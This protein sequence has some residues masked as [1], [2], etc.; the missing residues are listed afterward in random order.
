GSS[1]TQDA[2]GHLG[3]DGLA[4]ADGDAA[5]LSILLGASTPQK[6]VVNEQQDEQAQHHAD[7]EGGEHLGKR[8]LHAYL[9][10]RWAIIITLLYLNVNII[11]YVF[12]IM[13]AILHA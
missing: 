10:G 12:R 13:C 6:L 11:G 3:V 9:L 8:D 7:E 2:F 5:D 1:P 4:L